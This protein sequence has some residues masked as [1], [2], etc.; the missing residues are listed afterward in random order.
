MRDHVSLLGAFVV[1]VY[2]RRPSYYKWDRHYWW[3]YKLQE[4]KHPSS[5][6]TRSCEHP[7]IDPECVEMEGVARCLI[8]IADFA[9]FSFKFTMI[10]ACSHFLF[11]T[12]SSSLCVCRKFAEGIIPRCVTL[13]KKRHFHGDDGVEW[14][15]SNLNTDCCTQ[16][17]P[18]T[19]PPPSPRLPVSIPFH[20]CVNSRLFLYISS[21]PSCANCTR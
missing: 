19:S 13:K 8:I 14:C 2:R 11:H 10:L 15:S 16:K 20:Q 17:L 7:C 4:C 5:T 1:P 9:L 18:P 21:S 6:N 12:L 3:Q